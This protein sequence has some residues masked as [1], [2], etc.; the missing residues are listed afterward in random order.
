MEMGNTTMDGHLEVEV[1]VLVMQ[2]TFFERLQNEEWLP[3]GRNA[4]WVLG[5]ALS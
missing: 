3:R 2:G 4:C 5:V 1:Q